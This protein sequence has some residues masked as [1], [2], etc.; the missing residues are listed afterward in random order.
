MDSSSSNSA[1]EEGRTALKGLQKSNLKGTKPVTREKTTI[2]N[3]VDGTTT[4]GE[5]TT[6]GKNMI[7]KK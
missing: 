2:V 1:G 6:K 7:G 4:Q 3:N 5:K